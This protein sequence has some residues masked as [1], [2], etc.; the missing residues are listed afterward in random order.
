LARKLLGNK[1]YNYNIDVEDTLKKDWKGMEFDVVVGNPP[2]KGNFHLA[3]LKKAYEISKRW[4]IWVHPS[5]WIINRKGATQEYKN[6]KNL[7][8]PGL[9]ETIIFNGNPVFNVKLA[10]PF[11]ILVID[12][13]VNNKTIKFEDRINNKSDIYNDI[14]QINKFGDLL[15]FDLEKKVLNLANKDS[16][17]DHRNVK[18]GPYYINIARIR[19]NVELKDPSK[20]YKD[21]FFSLMPRDRGVEKQIHQEFYLSFKN[22]EE[23]KNCLSFIRTRWAMFGMSIYKIGG[24]SGTSELKGI[25]WLD[26]SESWTEDKFE[27]LINATTAEIAFVKE[28]IPDYYGITKKAK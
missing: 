22:N 15:Y 27:K 14:N 13:S 11:G 1:P 25:P 3:F 5:N 17:F 2:Y 12:K 28:N 21:D 19:G 24:S 16:F 26:W 4:I 8:N 9:K 20:I 18:N 23:A 10:S 6:M 7:I